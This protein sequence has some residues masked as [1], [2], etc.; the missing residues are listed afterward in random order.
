MGKI[1]E[2]ME[3][4]AAEGRYCSTNRCGRGE[5]AR[6]LCHQHYLDLLAD[7][8]ATRGDQCE[9]DEDEDKCGEGRWSSGLCKRHYHIMN[10]RRVRRKKAE[11]AWAEE[12]V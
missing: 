1:K 9:W 10:M 4:K 2:R 5:Y 8:R 6:G 7:Q 11:L 12:V 3:R